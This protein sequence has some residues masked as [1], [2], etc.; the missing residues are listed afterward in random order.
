MTKPHYLPVDLS[1]EVLEHALAHAQQPTRHCHIC[2]N[3]T[4]IRPEDYDLAV[5][6]RLYNARLM[7]DSMVK[8]LARLQYPQVSLT[9]IY[10]LIYE[11][12]LLREAKAGRFVAVTKEM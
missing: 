6:A 2:E 1:H 4:K 12:V 10:Q 7:L 8:H 9:A 5:D 11:M 3:G